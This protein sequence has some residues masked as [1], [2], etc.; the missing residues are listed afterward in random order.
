MQC[1]SSTKTASRHSWCWDLS[2]SP[3]ATASGLRMPPFS[4]LLPMTPHQF[5]AL[6]PTPGSTKSPWWSTSGGHERRKAVLLV[7]WTPSEGSLQRQSALPDTAGGRHPLQHSDIPS[8]P[9][10]S[11][12]NSN[13]ASVWP[14]TSS[15]MT[16]S[17]S[18]FTVAND[19]QPQLAKYSCN[20]GLDNFVEQLASLTS[21]N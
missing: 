12:Q 11:I 3:L 8:C 6:T 17:C 10:E 15:L 4:T 7:T 13:H 20:R 9:S 5:P 18:D 19:R 21:M 1:A 16:S 14:F 2:L